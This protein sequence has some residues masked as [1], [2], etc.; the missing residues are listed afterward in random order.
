MRD[1]VRRI[2]EDGENGERG[3]LDDL[4]VGFAQNLSR[5]LQQFSRGGF[6][7]GTRRVRVPV[8]Q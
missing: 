2:H 7:L 5:V 6:L 1:S 8:Q 4:G 3:G